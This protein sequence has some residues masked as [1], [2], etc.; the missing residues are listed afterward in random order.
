MHCV[1]VWPVVNE[2]EGGVGRVT[3]RWEVATVNDQQQSVV[4][5][6]H[7]SQTVDTL[8][9]SHRLT[10][11]WLTFIQSM[12]HLTIYSNNNNNNNNGTV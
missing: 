6:V 5:T 8:T 10:V 4:P 3:V 7:S 1:C 9:T 12:M 2:V 11:H